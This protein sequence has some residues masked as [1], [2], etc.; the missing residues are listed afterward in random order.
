[1]KSM[2][3]TIAVGAALLLVPQAFGQGGGNG[4]GGNGGN[5]GGTGNGQNGNNGQV[6][7]VP[8]FDNGGGQGTQTDPIARY[9]M[10]KDAYRNNN[11]TVA[12]PL[13]AS[14]RAQIDSDFFLKYAIAAFDLFNSH[15]KRVVNEQD[16][17]VKTIKDADRANRREQDELTKDQ[18]LAAKRNAFSRA[19]EA[20]NSLPTPKN[21]VATGRPLNAYL[22]RV[23]E[24]GSFGTLLTV[25]SSDEFKLRRPESIR[26]S[27]GTGERS[28]RL[29]VLGSKLP[30]HPP[31]FLSLDPGLRTKLD[32]YESARKDAATVP[33][34]AQA[35]A[36]ALDA[37]TELDSEV[38]RRHKGMKV[39]S[40]QDENYQDSLAWKKFAADERK[41]LA[42]LG[43]NTPKENFDGKT[44]VDLLQYL[45]RN[46][47]SF[48]AA[49]PGDEDAYVA[50]HQQ[51]RDLCVKVGEEPASKSEDRLGDFIKQTDRLRERLPPTEKNP[52]ILPPNSGLSG[53]AQAGS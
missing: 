3:F 32:A 17:L 23:N 48:A 43:V 20:M 24:A 22:D 31:A 25:G 45:R 34:K 10:V 39:Q 16:Y 44:I 15:R 29:P 30:F 42:W 52:L 37:L 28:A 27:T 14:A 35:V 47:Y 49:D 4:G 41:L 8:G 38:L 6:V 13:D 26:I 51:L 1:M 40:F 21:V 53:P 18:T 12:P 33:T 7:V 46:G 9:L 5:G 36:A 50:L 2:K 11:F 19:I